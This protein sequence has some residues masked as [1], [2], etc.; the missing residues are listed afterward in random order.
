MDPHG[1]ISLNAWPTGSS[2]VRRCGFIGGGVAL[3]EEVC[4]CGDG[5]LRS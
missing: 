1:L 2:A 4:H 3:L 5:A